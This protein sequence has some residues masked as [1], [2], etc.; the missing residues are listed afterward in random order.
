MDYGYKDNIIIPIIVIYKS[1][2]MLIKHFYLRFRQFMDKMTLFTAIF[3]LVFLD[4]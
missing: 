2:S 1:K 3:R 4:Y